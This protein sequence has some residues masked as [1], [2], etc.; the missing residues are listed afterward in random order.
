MISFWEVRARVNVMTSSF[1][2]MQKAQGWYAVWRTSRFDVDLVLVQE[3]TCQKP[4]KLE[5]GSHSDLKI[6]R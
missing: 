3:Q 1:D 4:G 5:I 2:T 6:W